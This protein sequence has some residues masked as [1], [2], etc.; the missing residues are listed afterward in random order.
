VIG[1]EEHRT[2]LLSQRGFVISRSTIE[3]RTAA[4]AAAVVAASCSCLPQSD[5]R[6]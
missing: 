2:R 3:P 1:P 4:Q 5:L 6:L